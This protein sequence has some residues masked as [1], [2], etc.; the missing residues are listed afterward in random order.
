MK[1]PLICIIEDEKS[2]INP[3]KKLLEINK[4]NALYYTNGREALEGLSNASIRPDLIITDFMMPI[5]DGL[6]FRKKQLETEGLAEIPTY[7]LTASLGEVDL[8]KYG[9]KGRLSKPVSIKAIL[10]LIKSI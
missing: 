9:F 6:Q 2:I 1:K 10:S 7:L 4:V 3:L 5:M 8:Q